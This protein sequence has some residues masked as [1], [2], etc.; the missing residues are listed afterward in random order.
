MRGPSTRAAGR[1][2]GIRTHDAEPPKFRLWPLSY[3]PELP[4]RAGD[5]EATR[6]IRGPEAARSR[7]RGGT[8]RRVNALSR[9]LNERLAPRLRDVLDSAGEPRFVAA[10]VVVGA[11][12]GAASIAFAEL[13]RLVQW[14][15]IGAPDLAKWVVPWLP[16]W[17]VLLV[18]A[19]G[20]LLVGLVGRYLSSEVRGH[21]VPEVMEAVA[22]RGGRIR[23]RVAFTKSLA[24]ALT[25]GTG[26]SVG[27][28]G[29]I[30]QIGAAVGSAIGQ[31]L[32]LPSDQLRALAA[33]GAAG[34]IAAAFNAPIAGTFFALEVI[35]R[36]FS[37]RT[38]GPV[39]LCAV[40]ATLV[41]RLHFGDDPAFVVPPFSM[42]APWETP[43]AVPLGILC[44]VVAVGFCRTLALLERT[45]ARI[46]IPSTLKPALGGFGV[47]ALILVSP[48]LY[49][50]GYETMDATLAGSLP[51]RT[52][53]LLLVLKPVATSLTLASGGSGG[54]FLPS[55]YIGG[56]VGGL[57]SL[58]IGGLLPGATASAGAWATVGMAGLLAGS[59]HAPVTAVLL[60]FELTQS[61]DVMLPVMLA[62]AVAT[63]V[64][65]GLQ[66]DSI[67]TE[68]L[69]ARGIDL[70]RR[71]DL[72]LRRVSA[73]EVM[74]AD[75][76]AV[77][78]DA[79]LDVVLARFLD[80]D[81]GA[82]FV[83]DERGRLVGQVSI[84]DVKASLGESAALGGLV[85][86]GD[87]TEEAA[88]AV[89]DT[90]VADCLDRLTRSGRELL[91]VVDSEGRLL[92][93]LSVRAIMD[94]LAREALHGEWVGV[95]AAASPE[96]DRESLRLTS[97]IAVRAVEAPA[98][99]WGRSV[100]TLD[101]RRRWHVSAI[102]LRHH[103]V[104]EAV[105][106]DRLLEAGD[107]LVLMG[108]AREIGRVESELRRRGSE[109]A[110]AERR[111]SA[112]RSDE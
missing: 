80:S 107:S 89:E 14:A 96:R 13:I 102:A 69:R 22:L 50:V 79:P 24:S 78:R 103:G 100:R 17:R 57:F 108:E 90:S 36:N 105:D 18:P 59:S 49:G 5:S 63:L 42:G 112:E 32:A 99:W 39:V 33:A 40:F 97:G 58:A 41:A 46:P 68:K 72:A 70:D 48:D 23:R 109:A 47:G 6:R 98:A 60:A 11:L 83:I 65:R 84:H 64:A 106:P 81:L 86:A 30:V 92:G 111:Q 2:G 54:V 67:Y 38:F 101:L 66:R 28:E 73:G 74:Q 34:G 44:G 104:D 16:R 91:G 43:L 62:S 10:A 9:L 15:A 45:F 26:G 71:E 27:R 56:L 31:G 61:Y 29:P 76:P 53:A 93:V 95:A 51:W 8:L 25:I 19:V 35:A 77:R 75:P 85:V 94:L 7:G 55:L 4:P 37:A 20:G 52:L 12:T 88:R 21:G 87:V 82:V 1:G 3:T 110:R